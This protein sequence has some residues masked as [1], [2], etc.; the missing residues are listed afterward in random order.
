MGADS[1]YH[2]YEHIQYGYH[3]AEVAQRTSVEH[4]LC[5]IAV[6]DIRKECGERQYHSQYPRQYQQYLVYFLV[7]HTIYQLDKYVRYQRPQ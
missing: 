6:G 5:I 7:F 2:Q 4:V 3:L 1:T